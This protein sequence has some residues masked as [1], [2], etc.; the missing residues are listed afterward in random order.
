MHSEPDVAASRPVARRGRESE[1]SKSALTR[2][3]ILNAA[4]IV[5]NRNGYAGTRLSDIAAIAELQAPA[6]YYH[7][8]SRDELIQE[9]VQVGLRRTMNHV[10]KSLDALGPGARPME[11]ILTAVGAHLEIV[12]RES[13]FAAAAIRNAAQL[14]PAIRDVQLLDQRRYGA[15]WRTLVT[16]GIAEGEVSGDLDPWAARMLVIGALNWAPEWWREERGT[17]EDIV[18]TARLLVRQGLSPG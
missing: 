12:L 1:T 3:R 4:A 7:F 15:L 14:P 18:H 5:L 2:E 10:R 13:E 17:L 6:I 9:V 16:E 11:R 8:A